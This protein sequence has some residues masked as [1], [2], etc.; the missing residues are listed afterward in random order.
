M[1]EALLKAGEDPNAVVSAAGDTALMLASRTGKPDAIAMLL[2]HGADANKTNTDGQT[3]L[4]WAAAAKNAAAVQLFVDHKADSEREDE[5]RAS[6][7][8]ARYHLLR[9]RIRSAA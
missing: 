9:A 4:M 3:P 5:E 6:A 1:I 8:A 2:N 7:E